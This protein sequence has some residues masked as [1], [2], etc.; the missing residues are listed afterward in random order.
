MCVC[1]CICELI[2]RILKSDRKEEGR[3][4]EERELVREVK[5]LNSLDVGGSH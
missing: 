5:A 4:W 3:R 2:G 1:V